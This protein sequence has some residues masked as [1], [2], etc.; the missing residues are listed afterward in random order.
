MHEVLPVGWKL[1]G[2]LSQLQLFHLR[3]Q[4]CNQPDIDLFHLLGRIHQETKLI[5]YF[6]EGFPVNQFKESAVGLSMSI[7]RKFICRQRKNSS[8]SCI[9]ASNSNIQRG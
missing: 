6:Q 5:Q 8:V 7:M 4:L 9:V 3:K 1:L 2:A